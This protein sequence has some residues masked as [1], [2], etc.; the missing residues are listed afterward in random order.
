MT[1]SLAADIRTLIGQLRRRLKKE[2]P[3]HGLTPPEQA[4]VIR[5]ERHGPATLTSLAEAE[6]VRSQSMGATV[7]TLKASGLVAGKPDPNDGRQ[8][9]LSLT[10]TCIDRL[11]AH[12]AAREDWLIQVITARYTPQ[13]QQTLATGI[14][15]LKRLLD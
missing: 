3:G 5:L 9:L 11:H 7:A 15:L 2:A 12:R 13:E 1:P 4:V 10:D 14:D 6:G 8:T